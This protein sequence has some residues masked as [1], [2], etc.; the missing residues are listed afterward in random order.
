VHAATHNSVSEPSIAI[1]QARF[2][3][4]KASADA[5][6]LHEDMFAE[7]IHAASTV[8]VVATAPTLL[9]RIDNVYV[10]NGNTGLKFND[11]VVV[12]PND[13]VTLVGSFNTVSKED[14]DETRVTIAI[15]NPSA[16]GKTVLVTPVASSEYSITFMVPTLDK[17]GAVSKGTQSTVVVASGE[18]L[19]LHI[20]VETRNSKKSAPTTTAQDS[21]KVWYMKERQYQ[22]R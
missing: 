6:A 12:F 9:N 20:Q 19:Q 2:P 5:A 10:H 4:T 17:Q 11:L 16:L 21:I 13:T 1:L 7:P 15:N 22:D 8:P 14:D 18:L 3:K